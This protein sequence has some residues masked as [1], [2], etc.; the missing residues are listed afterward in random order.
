MNDEAIAEVL[1]KAADGYE[2]GRYEWCARAGFLPG[3]SVPKMCISVA[4]AV[5]AGQLLVNDNHILEHVTLGSSQYI[6]AMALSNAA[7]KALVKH[8]E[9]FFLVNWNDY[10]ASGQAEVV[11]VLK[12]T[13]KKLRNGEL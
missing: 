13:A 10:H 8:L 2:S 6:E 1:E 4:T 7:A 5:A 12:T 11:E 9:L 3:E